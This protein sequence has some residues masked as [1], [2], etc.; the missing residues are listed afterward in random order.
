MLFL[1]TEGFQYIEAGND[2]PESVR[3]S[4]PF[5]N[6]YL[7]IYFLMDFIKSC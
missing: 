7:Y 3:I 1:K 2:I 5:E 6:M 4:F